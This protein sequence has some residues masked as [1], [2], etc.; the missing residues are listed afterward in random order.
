VRV[1]LS[2]GNWAEL[3]DIEQLNA[4]DRLAVRR[5]NTVPTDDTTGVPASWKDEMRVALLG[6]IITAWS[7]PGWPIPS[8][9][10]DRKTA[11][12]QVPLKDYNELTMAVEPYLD[13]VDYY[14]SK[15]NSGESA[16]TSED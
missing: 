10:P 4:G 2:N 3:R 5:V 9:T 15:T 7:Y 8:I 12:L 11:V 16:S 6:E 13:V 1:D 14:P